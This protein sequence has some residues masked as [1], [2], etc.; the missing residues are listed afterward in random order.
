MQIG[1]Q[2]VGIVTAVVGTGTTELFETAVT[3]EAVVWVDGCQ[4]E[5]QVRGIHLVEQ[6]DI[7]TTTTNEIAW[8]HMPVTNDTR[9]ITSTMKLRHAGLTYL[10]RGDAV[11]E[12]DI[13]GREDHV[14]A[15]CER[16]VG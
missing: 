2:R 1:N 15:L 11:I 9:A 10:M 3:G 5:V 16:Q 8:C 4:F 6:Q 14:F 13:K 7:E 12:V